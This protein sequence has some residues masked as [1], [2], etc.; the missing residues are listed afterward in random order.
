[1]YPWIKDNI[2]SIIQNNSLSQIS[3]SIGIVDSIGTII[4]SLNMQFRELKNKIRQEQRMIKQLQSNIVSSSYSIQK[5]IVQNC[6][7]SRNKDCNSRLYNQSNDW[8]RVKYR[9]RLKIEKL[10]FEDLKT[11]IVF[12]E[13]MEKV[14]TKL[15]A[16]FIID[17]KLILL[18]LERRIAG[19]AFKMKR[20]N[21]ESTLLI[22]KSQ[23]RVK[24]LTLEV[25]KLKKNCESCDN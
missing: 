14:L 17:S 8:I 5:L 13:R 12:Y 9:A 10:L 24:Q 25:S 20:S 2:K 15:N 19:I 3:K 7:L 4:D 16:S 22:K 6:Q 21:D 23:A 11:E 18:L 1:M